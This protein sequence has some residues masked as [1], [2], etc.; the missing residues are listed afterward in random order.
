MIT[1]KFE[2]M[3]KVRQ[4]VHVALRTQDEIEYNSGLLIPLPVRDPRHP[5]YLEIEIKR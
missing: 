3:E 4:H 1:K 5:V 2:I